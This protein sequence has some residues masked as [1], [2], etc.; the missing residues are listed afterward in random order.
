MTYPYQISLKVDKIYGEQDVNITLYTGITTFV[1]TN[2]SGK[3]QTLKA[4]RDKLKR[5]VGIDKVRY[6][7]SNRLGAMEDYRSK[8][9]QYSHYTAEKYS[10][11]NREIKNVRKRIETASGDFFAM[12]ERKDVYIKTQGD[13]SVV[14][15]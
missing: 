3:T 14:F 1:G 13:G 4:L 2:A 8:T 10:I 6:L 9:N 15:V 11:G 7:S 12:D 5:D